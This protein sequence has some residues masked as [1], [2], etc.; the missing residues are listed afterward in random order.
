MIAAKLKIIVIHHES[1]VKEAIIRLVDEWS[2][3]SI[4]HFD[5]Q[6][7]MSWLWSLDQVY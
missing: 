7:A 1:H 6:D 5:V 2:T 4:L 3:D